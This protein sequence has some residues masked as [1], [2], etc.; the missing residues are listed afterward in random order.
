ME[1][2]F[3]R[4]YH[5]HAKV[6]KATIRLEHK[7][8]F[9]LEVDWA[10]VRIAFFDAKSGKMSQASLFVAVLPCSGII[11]AEPCGVSPSTWILNSYIFVLN[12]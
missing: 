12:L 1:T 7:C 10:G 6:H 2:Q 5:L 11:Y 4:Y 9:S 3:R 8:A